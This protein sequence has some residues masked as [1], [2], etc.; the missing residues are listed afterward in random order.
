MIAATRKRRRI[1]AAALTAVAILV[2]V[3]GYVGSWLA[4][5]H[6]AH[7]GHI[8]PAVTNAVAPLF[9]PITG[10]CGKELPGAKLLNAMW[11]KVNPPKSRFVP[12]IGVA[13]IA[14]PFAPPRP[15]HEKPRPGIFTLTPIEPGGYR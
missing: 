12:M 13:E 15:D 1:R 8:S 9:R 10:Y 3:N 4:V 2:F 14:A 5:S 11:W 6:S 7:H